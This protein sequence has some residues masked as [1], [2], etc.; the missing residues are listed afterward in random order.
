LLPQ[1]RREGDIDVGPRTAV[2]QVDAARHRSVEVGG[3]EAEQ[4]GENRPV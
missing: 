4:F 1:A 2:G 3:I